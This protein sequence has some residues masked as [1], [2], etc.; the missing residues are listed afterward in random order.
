MF[1]T[2]NLT[3]HFGLVMAC[4]IFLLALSCPPG[5]NADAHARENL[6][7]QD[8]TVQ[9][10]ITLTPDPQIQRQIGKVLDA[11]SDESRRDELQALVEMA[12]SDSQKLI[13]QLLY[14]SAYGTDPAG[15]HD[16]KEGMALAGF[17]DL[18]KISHSQIA[19]A[20]WPYLGTT[21]AQLRQ[22][23]R[24]VFDGF[25]F[26]F[27]QDFLQSRLR[28]GQDLPLELIQYM[29]QRNP[30]EAL[31][32]M[33]RTWA[34][35]Q[36]AEESSKRW[37]PLIWAEH[38]VSDTLWKQEHQ[39]LEKTRVEPEAATQIEKLVGDPDWWV[40]LYA[41]EILRQ[42]PGFRSA[43]LLE[44]L[45]QDDNRLVRETARASQ[46]RPHAASSAAPAPPASPA[47]EEQKK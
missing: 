13:E 42:H 29:Y 34:V 39:F 8:I 36:S 4:C 25:S 33:A 44:R 38:V 20:L 43:E 24:D 3:T 26:T 30:A 27:F 32:T 31:L 37:R 22:K 16:L 15:K 2:A 19:T 35:Q 28:T 41:A 21:D 14:Y 18:L 5:T 12:G 17:S 45:A 40:R 9:S 1:A 10:E 6:I 11:A 7:E 46:P 23:L 47:T